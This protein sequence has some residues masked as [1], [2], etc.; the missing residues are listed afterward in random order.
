MS[1]LALLRNIFFIVSLAWLLMPKAHAGSVTVVCPVEIPRQSVQVRAPAG[2]TP[3]VPFEYTPGVPL[4]GAG[5]MYGPPSIMAISKPN[6]GSGST[7]KWVGLRVPTDGIWMACFYGDGG[8]QDMI[9]S[10]RLDD[11]TKECAVTYG[12]GAKRRVQLDIRCRS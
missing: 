8:R 1:I 10:Q 2:W 3:F 4:T 11:A 5:V 6:G 12:K 7:A 9:L